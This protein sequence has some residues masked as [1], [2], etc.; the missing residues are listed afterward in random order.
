MN[1]KNDKPEFKTLMEYAKE[2]HHRYFRAISA[3]YAFEA[4]KEVRAP[5]LI[6]QLDAEEN[7]KT[8][9]RYNC[10]FTPELI[11]LRL[12]IANLLLEKL[13]SRSDYSI[14]TNLIRSPI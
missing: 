1:T 9:S 2:L 14:H 3:F 10:L 13:S 4:L 12:L 7:A 8:M 6:G 11:L 5:N